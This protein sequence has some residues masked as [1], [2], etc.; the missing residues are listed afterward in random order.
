M[1]YRRLKVEGASYFFTL[2]TEHRR[3]LFADAETVELLR[4]AIARI[5]ER[6][7]FEVEAQ[8]VMPDHLHALWRMPEKDADY[9]TRWRL[10]KEAFTKA[11]VKRHGRAAIDPARA[12]RGE[13]S[14]WQRRFWE[15]LIRDEEDFGAHLDYIHLNPVHHGYV[16][17]PRDWPHSTFARW[18]ARG[19][20]EPEWGSNEKP[21][22]PEWAR[23]FE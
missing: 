18:V 16:T 19:V 17:A 7:P 6:H 14:L 21:Q 1:R 2:V 10:I 4:Q 3:K 20:Y 8:V 15:H 12:A 23:R 22:L 5:G 11:C 9:S 13:Q